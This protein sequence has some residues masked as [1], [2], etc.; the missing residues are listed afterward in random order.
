MDATELHDLFRVE[1]RDMAEPY[2]FESPT[3]YSYIDAA[4]VEFCRLTEGI[5]DARTFVLDIVADE[6]WYAVDPKILK[7]RRARNKATGRPV[8]TVSVERVEQQGI[9]FDGRTG[10]LKA[11]V[12]GAE[13]NMVRAWPVP[14]EAT[15]IQLEVFR[16]PKTVTEDRVR[17]EIDPQHHYYLL[18]WAKHLAFDTRD[19]DVFD[20][21]ASENYRAKFVAYCA[22]AKAEQGRARHSAGAVQYGEY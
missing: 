1:M 19:A 10:P 11:L 20:P 7:L 8:D 12:T 16:M 22:R 4:Q 6:E 15:Q 13:K 18:D 2:L 3:I 17:L 9:R 21:R 5:E 14:A